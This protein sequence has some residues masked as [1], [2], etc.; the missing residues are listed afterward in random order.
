MAPIHPYLLPPPP[1]VTAPFSPMFFHPSRSAMSTYSPLTPPTHRL[2]PSLSIPNGLPT[3][4]PAHQGSPILH[5]TNNPFLPRPLASAPITPTRITPPPSH[6]TP[7]QFKPAT[8]TSPTTS[9]PSSFYLR[10]TSPSIPV[11][12]PTPK[13]SVPAIP[14]NMWPSPV[15]F[16]LKISCCSFLFEKYHQYF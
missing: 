11:V 4:P 14:N 10:Q 15:R 1:P 9:A 2:Y 5:T 7:I 3:P 12:K 16:L 13:P 6:L 8:T